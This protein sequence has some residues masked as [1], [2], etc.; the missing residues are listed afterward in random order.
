MDNLRNLPPEERLRRLKRI[1]E[2]K[3]KEIDA[4]RK[5]IQESEEELTEQ[6]K[7][8]EKIPIPEV[9]QDDERGL[10]E[11]GKELLRTHHGTTPKKEWSAAAVEETKKKSDSLEDV[12]EEEKGKFASSPRNVEYG[13]VRGQSMRGDYVQQLS[14][15]P[16]KQLSQEMATLYQATE[17]KGYVSGEEVRR[18]QYI[19]GAVEEKLKAVDEG[20]YS[21]SEDVAQAALLTQQIGSQMQTLYQSKKRS[22]IHD[23]YQGM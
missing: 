14:Q 16:M 2:E 4:A 20:R 23:W 22:D 3:K 21:L 10:S 19:V 15:A 12:V 18:A 8:K 7:I 6:D 17:E 1:E 11:G 9:S 5:A 13:V